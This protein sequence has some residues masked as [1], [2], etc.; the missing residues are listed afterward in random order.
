MNRHFL[1]ARHKPKVFLFNRTKF[2][3]LSIDRMYITYLGV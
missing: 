1:R 3:S 2:E